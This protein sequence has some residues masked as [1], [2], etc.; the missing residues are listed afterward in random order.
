MHRLTPKTSVPMALRQVLLHARPLTQTEVILVRDAGARVAAEKVVSGVDVPAF[1]CSHVDGYAVRS[2]DLRRSS[3]QQ[4]V[5]LRLMGEVH[6]GELY[7]Y[8]LRAGE[9]VAVATGAPVPRGADAVEMFENVEVDGAAVRFHAPVA[10]GEGVDPAGGD[11]TRGTP[12]IAPGDVLTPPL[13]GLLSLAG[14]DRVRIY[15]QPRVA[16]LSSGNELRLPGY[17]RL[18]T[19]KVFE[20]NS[21]ALAS[22]VRAAGGRPEVLPPIRDEVGALE[23]GLRSAL[24][25]TDLVV[26]SGGSS[27]GERDLL[28]EVFPRLGTV[29]FHGVKVRPGMPTIVAE[30]RGKLLFG[31]PGHP[32]S[33]LTNA[34]WLL[35]PA[36]RKVARLPGDGTFPLRV[37]MDKRTP[38][39][40][41]GFSTVLP[42]EIR[43]EIARSTFHGSHFIT[44]L[45]PANGYAI[46]P[47]SKRELL[48]GER[49]F[50]R[51]AS[52]LEGR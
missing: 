48:K 18:P 33:C 20:A 41:H 37:V 16:I 35:V 17:G 27:V 51:K 5:Q 45:H 29:L 21:S 32:A 38:L 31:M 39:H 30:C 52:F 22:L 8:R 4:P 12:L 24:S 6:A 9:A 15:A 23:T 19:G 49:F 11:L 1:P 14:K 36:L 43:G 40:G 47:P 2:A 44:S 50:A 28:R 7:P 13:L 34:V 26:I 10:S 25:S 42:L 3:P 46:F